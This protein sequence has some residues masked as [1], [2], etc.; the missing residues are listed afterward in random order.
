MVLIEY[1]NYYN[2]SHPHQ[3]IDQQTPIPQPSPATGFIHRRKILGGIIN[4][5]FRSSSQAALT[6]A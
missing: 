4:D 5:Y 3:G 2:P 6:S 1:S